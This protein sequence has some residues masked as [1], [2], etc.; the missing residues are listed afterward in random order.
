MI[1]S[2]LY[3]NEYLYI[4]VDEGEAR[5]CLSQVNEACDPLCLKKFSSFEG[6]LTSY[7][8]GR[9]QSSWKKRN[10][11]ILTSMA[12]IG[13][14][15]Y[16]QIGERLQLIRYGGGYFD[17]LRYLRN[18]DR[19]YEMDISF[20]KSLSTMCSD[21]KLGFGSLRRLTISGVR[22][23]CSYNASTNPGPT[24][25]CHGFIKKLDAYVVA[26]R[27]ATTMEQRIDRGENVPPVL[28]G[29]AGRPKLGLPSKF[30]KKVTNGKSGGRGVWMADTFESILC[31]RYARPLLEF[32]KVTQH[33]IMLGF[34]K[35]GD[36]PVR[37][38]HVMKG[39]NLFINGDFS[40]FDSTVQNAVI[41]RAFDVIRFAFGCHRG[42]GSFDDKQ[43][44]Y[45]EENFIHSKLVMP[46]G[47]ISVKPGG[48]PSGTGLTSVMDSIVNA[49]IFLDVLHELEGRGRIPHGSGLF[50]YGDDNLTCFKLS[51]KLSEGK[52][53]ATGLMIRSELISIMKNKFMMDLSES[54]TKVCTH[55]TV[56]YGVP[57]VPGEIKNYSSQAIQK[58]RYGLIEK[59]G[60]QLTFDEKIIVLNAEPIGPLE[61]WGT[62]RWT[63]VFS[64][65][66]SFLSYYF[67]EDGKMIRPTPQVID[68]IVNP[69]RNVRTLNDHKQTLVCALIENFFNN[70][71][72]N[73]IMH[74]M[75]DAFWMERMGLDSIQLA[76]GDFLISMREA[77]LREGREWPSKKSSR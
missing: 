41:R 71:T 19:D 5:L 23:L 63:Y 42:D 34:N 17:G 51:E 61:G 35:F 38:L 53:H 14:S 60:R 36:S 1:Y 47:L 48:I 72:V 9:R 20:S 56:G 21:L 75:Y 22:I 65:R 6:R 77:R 26:Y 45:I 49:V 39:Y 3:K 58:Y 13:G 57:N 29:L 76:K 64:R 8:E 18:Y 10:Y 69:E 16:R 27:V 55:L 67:K 28:F 43:I 11:Y 68:R 54:D 52:R 46:D 4:P 32:F 44:A 7:V 30:L 24:F 73:R 33:I 59:L 12:N 15:D 62:H 25:K 31:N 37:M 50:V 74:Y 40:Q 2:I 66:P 70:H